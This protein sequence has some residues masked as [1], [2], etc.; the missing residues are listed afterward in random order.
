MKL[1]I[2]EG[3]VFQELNDQLF[4][5]MRVYHDAMLLFRVT[6]V[7]TSSH[8]GKH[9]PNSLHYKNLALDLRSRDLN[10]GQKE[11]LLLEMK[12]GLGSDYVVVAETDHVHVQFG[13]ATDNPEAS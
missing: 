4:K 13:K 11:R 8:D 12:S 5:I 6:P 2:K 9:L 1:E 10:D 3:V 7:I